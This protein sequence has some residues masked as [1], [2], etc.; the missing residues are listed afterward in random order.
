MLLV[1]PELPQPWDS[2]KG[3]SL[4]S[5]C[6]ECCLHYWSVMAPM[7]W[8]CWSTEIVSAHWEMLGDGELVRMTGNPPKQTI[9]AQRYLHS[10]L[11][12]FHGGFIPVT[13]LI[14]HFPTQHHVLRCSAPTTMGFQEGSVP[15]SLRFPNESSIFQHSRA[16]HSS[17]INIYREDFWIA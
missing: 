11:I 16:P 8:S 1:G 17:L 3:S 15:S 4:G 12:P 7:A 5:L 2:C 14:K 9:E 13:I 6:T 10:I